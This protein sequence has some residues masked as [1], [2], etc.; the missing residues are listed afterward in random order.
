MP[1]VDH[2]AT[3]PIQG[4]ALPQRLRMLLS[5]VRLDPLEQLDVT[6]VVYF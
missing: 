3:F 4:A 2:L 1:A 5:P 6:L